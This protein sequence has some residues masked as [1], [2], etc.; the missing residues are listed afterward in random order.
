[1][2]KASLHIFGA[3]ILS[4]MF[5]LSAE[6][7]HIEAGEYRPS[8]A[9]AAPQFITITFQEP[10]DV[11]P[12]VTALI[13][14][15]GPE[16]AYLRIRS[17][18]ETGFEFILTQPPSLSGGAPPEIIHYIAIEPGITTLPNGVV[19]AAGRHDTMSTLTGSGTTGPD[20]YDIVPFGVTLS[21]SASVLANIQTLNNAENFT[22]STFLQPFLAAGVNFITNSTVQL[23]LERAETT[24]FGTITQPET[25]GWIAFPSGTTGS[26][27]DTNSQTINWDARVTENNIRGVDNGCFS[28]TFSSTAF[29]TAR[30]VATKATRNGADGGWLRRCSLTNTS[31]GLQ[32]DEDTAL[33]AERGHINERA[34]LLSFSGSFHAILDGE[35][36]GNK[37][38]EMVSNTDYS[39]P[40][41]AVLYRLTAENVGNGA[42]DDGSVVFSDS[43]PPEL[44]LRVIDI[45]GAGSGPVRFINGTPNSGLSF[46]F[47]SL[48]STSDDVDFSNDNGASF[49]Y[50][51]T[52]DGSG[53]DTAITHI[54]ISPSGAF[55]GANSG[56][57]PNFAVEFEAVIK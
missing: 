11:R 9:N 40:G 42:I 45:D 34:S 43:L 41:N 22:P 36:T 24:N 56:G 47:T 35:L 32:V 51:P 28:N 19:I 29:A 2:I 20:I 54:R 39:L 53:A 7:R 3:F 57:I 33:N 46:N 13:T 55:L 18:S 23:S 12:V 17:V 31:I 38:V 27:T 4:L 16:P 30:V 21:S 1:M 10:F 37:T 6:A 15:Q 14:N 49:N 48:A 44:A 52:A 25:I 26:L 5:T 8:V 50:V